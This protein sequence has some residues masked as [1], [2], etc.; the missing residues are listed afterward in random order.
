MRPDE[1]FLRR[2]LR[3]RLT[4]IQPSLLTTV[5][6]H[7]QQQKAAH[8]NS[9]ALAVFKPGELVL[10]QNHRG[11]S[12]WLNG[13][14]LRRKGPVSYLVTVGSKVHYCHVDYLL[15]RGGEGCNVLGTPLLI[16]IVIT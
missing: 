14:I 9:K 10:V 8:D 12:K 4:L 5:Q 1:L 15:R 6:K 16:G 13:R 2:K 7:Q 11:A 3:T